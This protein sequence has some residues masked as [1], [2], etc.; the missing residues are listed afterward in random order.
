M[1][2]LARGCRPPS[3]RDLPLS[4]SLSFSLS[5]FALSQLAGRESR[6]FTVFGYIAYLRARK[7]QSI[8]GSLAIPTAVPRDIDLANRQHRALFAAYGIQTAVRIPENISVHGEQINYSLIIIKDTYVYAPS[9]KGVQ[10][11]NESRMKVAKRREQ[12]CH[13][14]TLN[15]LS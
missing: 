6:L 3:A 4:L 11:I 10:K 9:N 5:L 12:F 13:S 8:K 1:R 7:L 2:S 14:R 15:H